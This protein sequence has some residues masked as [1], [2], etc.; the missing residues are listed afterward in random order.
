MSQPIIT[1]DIS[2]VRP[3]FSAGTS[4]NIKRYNQLKKMFSEGKEYAVLAEP[5]PAGKDKITWH[6]EFDGT[7]E[8]FNKLTEDDRQ[9][10]KGR[11][12]YQ[13]NR[14]YK[15]A[16]HQLYH[17]SKQDVNEIFE[18][19]DSCIEI[20]DYDNIFRVTNASGK[21]NYVLIKWGFI[22][23]DFNS[24][25]GLVKKLI[26]I[27]VDTIK[28]KVLNNGKA[29]S[30]QKVTLKHLGKIY[31]FVTDSLGYVSLEDVPLGDSFTA[32]T[33][34]KDTLT[35]YVC[36]GSDEY[37][38]NV[39][40]KS[41]DMIFNIVDKKGN[42]YANAEVSFTYEGKTYFETANSQGKIILRDI[43][44]NTEVV[45]KQKEMSEQYICNS[46]QKIYVFHG[47][48]P[49]SELEVIVITESGEPIENANVDITIAGENQVLKSNEKG[50][51]FIDEI[52]INSLVEIVC[53]GKDFNSVSSTLNT[54]EGLNS[55]ELQI[56]K[57]TSSGEMKI[58]VVDEQG[59]PI[60]GSLVRSEFDDYKTDLVTDENGEIFLPKVAY[61]S[62]VTCT[63]IID[64]LGMRRHK[65]T[66]TQDD[67]QYILKGI[68][69]PEKSVISDL[70]IHVQNKKKQDIPNLRVTISDGHKDIN[71]I[72]NAEGRVIVNEMPRN[73]KLYISTEY[74]NKTT[75]LEYE[76]TKEKELVNVFVGR[77]PWLFLLW[78]IPLLALV[79]FLI[80]KYLVPII[81]NDNPTPAVVVDTTENQPEPVVIPVEDTTQAVQPEPQPVVETPKGITLTVV[82]E[83]TG[84][85]IP[86]AEVNLTYG[87]NKV[88]GKTDANGKL[89]FAD[90]TDTT[91]LITVNI[92]AKNHDEYLGSFAFANEKTIIIPKKSIEFSEEILP[93]GTEIS[94][95]GF[96]STV[97]TFDLKKKKGK[98]YIYYQMNDVPD[99][100]IV[101][102]G[103]A[104]EIDNSKIIFDTKGFVKFSK[105]VSFNF[106]TD[107]GLITVKING[108]DENKTQW[109]FKVFCP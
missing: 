45:C 37:H 62:E 52:E 32:E 60:V 94:S 41:A 66:F 64:G 96:H 5:I 51:V 93:C 58:K 6:T 15:A 102:K 48:R 53:K 63:Q 25:S 18:I 1:T 3:V 13:V 4:E 75:K 56:R 12:K 71:R 2:A 43:P 80:Y 10:A 92:K 95:K 44:E 50:K 21:T 81:V 54:K 70:E 8:S 105:K 91:S 76:C 86:D 47:N 61:F 77:S 49:S 79:G 103:R 65:F 20:P 22:G 72:T 107:D 88:N 87:N 69:I 67:N 101:Y 59:H 26:P 84:N 17:G 39:G 40:V 83:E 23:D 27:K 106:Q 29:V 68:K 109:Y 14:M 85:I 42:P 89:N 55:V 38:L 97:K 73:K 78:L 35:E 100:M 36:D 90:I 24:G 99:Q 28:I 104:S 33:D 34:Q 74:K 46:E 31:N 7:P 82:D 19:L 108:G 98:V 11:I 16:F 57:N 30:N 9:K